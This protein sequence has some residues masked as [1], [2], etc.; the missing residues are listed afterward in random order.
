MTALHV[1]YDVTNRDG[2]V[3]EDGPAIDA[4]LDRLVADEGA[5]MASLVRSEDTTVWPPT[6]D[7]LVGLGGD[8]DVGVMQCGDHD[9]VWCSSAPQDSGWDI[10]AYDYMGTGHDFPTNAVIPLA[11]IRAAVHEYVTTGKRPE[12]VVWQKL[13]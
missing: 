1:W 7:L 6:L 4:F 11:Q 10:V 12:T 2:E 9:G 5:T 3:L 13:R 8:L